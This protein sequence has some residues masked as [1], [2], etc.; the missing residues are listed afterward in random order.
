MKV[1]RKDLGILVLAFAVMTGLGCKKTEQAEGV[2]AEPGKTVVALTGSPS[3]NMI[4]VFEMG[5]NAVKGSDAAA[6]AKELTG[7]MAQYNVADL[8]AKAKT[9]KDA[10]QGA[11][12]EEK[13]KFQSLTKEYQDM[14]AKMGAKNADFLAAHKEWSK[15][16]GLK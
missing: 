2:T 3:Q 9:A 16:W 6:A 7:I 4:T 13:D 10:G 14:A 12:K 1:N 8:R 5:V 15:V 11:T